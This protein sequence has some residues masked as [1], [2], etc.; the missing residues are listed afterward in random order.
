MLHVS[1]VIAP[2]HFFSVKLFLKIPKKIHLRYNRCRRRKEA[3]KQN[4]VAEVEG[5]RQ[6]VGH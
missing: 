3:A 1:S 4:L 5:V 2:F 6:A